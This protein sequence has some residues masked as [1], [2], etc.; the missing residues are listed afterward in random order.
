MKLRNAFLYTFYNDGDSLGIF[1]DSL[2]DDNRTLNRRFFDG[3]QFF[4][5][6]YLDTNLLSN[7]RTGSIEH[8]LLFGFDLT[9]YVED[10][11]FEFGDAAPVDI[12]NPVFDQTV[13]TTGQPTFDSITTRD[14]LGVYLQDQITLTEKFKVLLGGRLGHI[15]RGYNR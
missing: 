9:R 8:Q 1:N 12:F 6:Y 11:D 14:T 7:F 2:A 10:F 15:L 13:N 4:D 5:N 3:S